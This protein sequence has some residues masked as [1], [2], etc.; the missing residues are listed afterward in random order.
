MDLYVEDGFLIRTPLLPTNT[1]ARWAETANHRD[2]L[3]DLL[4]NDP[5][6]AEAV[7][8]SS[9]TLH[10]RLLEI[11]E[12]SSTLIQREQDRVV[13]T[14]VKFVARA[15]YR[16]TPF[17]LFASAGLGRWSTS[18]RFPQAG[19]AARRRFIRYDASVEAALYDEVN[20]TEGADRNVSFVVNPS[21][22][23]LAG[24]IFYLQSVLGRRRCIFRE[25]HLQSNELLRSI[26]E[27]RSIGRTRA[28][29]ADLVIELCEA[30]QKSAE[31]FVAELVSTGLLVTELE[32]R[33]ISSDSFDSTLEAHPYLLDVPAIRI[34]K[35][36]LESLRRKAESSASLVSEYQSALATLA[37][38]LSQKIDPRTSLQVDSFLDDDARLT[39]EE[40]FRRTL[41]DLLPRI[42]AA[43][44]TFDDHLQDL[45]NRIEQRFG[46]S[47]APLPLLLSDDYGCGAFPNSVIDSNLTRGLSFG[48]PSSVLRAESA[49]D[50]HVEQF[51]LEK[52]IKWHGS[53]EQVVQITTEE[54]EKLSK[55]VPKST[56]I[57][58]PEGLWA[59]IM[60]FETDDGTQSYLQQ[61]S[62]VS[63]FELFGRF[64][65][66]DAALHDFVNARMADRRAQLPADTVY[67]DIVFSPEGRLNNVV[68]RPG[69]YDWQILINRPPGDHEERALSLD[70]LFVRV[71][72]REIQLWSTS[73]NCRVLP[74]LTTAH[75]FLFTGLN[76]Y[77]LLCLLQLQ[78][79]P[80][81]HLSWPATL[82][83]QHML[84]RV[85]VEGLI[86]LPARWRLDTTDIDVLCEASATTTIGA[87]LRDLRSERRIPRFVVI[88]QSDAELPIDLE[89]SYS[90]RALVD[91]IG[92][93]REIVLTEAIG[94]NAIGANSPSRWNAE[95]VVPFRTFEPTDAVRTATLPR[96]ADGG[97]AKRLV[98]DLSA[99]DASSAFTPLSEWTYIKFYVGFGRIEE[100]LLRFL[101][102]LLQS[103]QKEDDRISFFFVRYSDPL[104]H[105][106]LRIRM[107]HD[108]DHTSV[109]RFLRN[110]G[111]QNSN[112]A[113]YWK[114]ELGTYARETR[115]YG[116]PESIEI[117]EDIFALDSQRVLD[118]IVL[119]DGDEESMQSRWAIA[120]EAALR[121][122]RLADL[123]DEEAQTLFSELS[124]GYGT[125]LKVSK[126]DKLKIGVKY[127][128]FRHEV[129]AITLQSTGCASIDRWRKVADRYDPSMQAALERLR[130]FHRTQALS[131]YVDVLK[132]ILHMQCDRLLL[133]NLRAQELFI[134][135]FSTR[136]LKAR[137]ARGPAARAER[138]AVIE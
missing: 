56:P 120:L 29:W 89:N 22:Y 12:G 112:G 55:I 79:R 128:D 103:L 36:S 23:L 58:K 109:A 114:M 45:R 119:E 76:A 92:L 68:S 52:F 81:L 116:G 39:E 34:A 70:D 50:Q 24:T 84:P 60:R 69:F 42:L 95:I 51:L 21:T 10:E 59:Q 99:L 37:S 115:R 73:L 86:V 32:P 65:C 57:S 1:L 41:Q 18:R 131:R 136:I 98:G 31:A 66:G 28:H 30:D 100:L 67:A 93:R 48:R 80:R 43:F 53:A 77:S 75:N 82:R 72:G 96:T 104:P 47:D 122:A 97:R 101:R 8:L 74:R 118:F 16:C 117:C 63:G 17:G 61:V 127:R 2:F 35:T 78:G 83:S 3:F 49:H 132:G 46:D 54:L 44:A 138:L 62:G 91:E 133:S 14:L 108:G 15:A 94:L 4:K 27:E 107:P 13:M 64:C 110:A 40:S 135:S 71:V 88:A 85:E 126:R 134:Y 7:Y 5:L 124:E 33:V 121:L 19:R 25:V 123:S 6:F 113:F 20:Q 105:L 38:S 111:Q 137:K 90:V 130:S 87:S 106:R 102:P 129:D 9:P 125:E 26:L 11:L